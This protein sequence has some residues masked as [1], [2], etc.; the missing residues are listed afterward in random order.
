MVNFW[1]K[2]QKPI[3]ILAPMDD[4]T[5]TV[6]RQ[7]VIKVGRPDIFFTEFV[8][9]EGLFSPG[10]EIVKRRLKFDPSEKP[11]VA[12]IWGTKPENFFKAA[13]LLQSLGFDGIDINMGCPDRKVTK[14]GAGAALIENSQL[15]K[16]IILATQKGAPKLPI[17]VKTR[18]GFKTIKTEQWIGFLLKMNLAAL[19]IH[20]RTAAQ[21][22]KAAANWEEINRVV[23][24]RD[25]LGVNTLIIGNGDVE[26]WAQIQKYYQEYKVDGV[27]IGRGIFHN[28]GAFVKTAKE[29]DQSSQEKMK[30]L[31]DHTE[32]F[33]KTWGSVKNFAILRKFFKIYASGFKGASNLRTKLM[34]ANSLEEVELI[35]QN[36]NISLQ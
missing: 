23:K 1:T 8:N 34:R 12:Q 14:K 15:A 9:C 4:V 13:Q 20:G 10:A 30:L 28:L 2:I 3:S 25:E 7:I 19:T 26:D 24:L 33:I 36:D 11:L 29:G 31:I 17:S 32:L 35:L 21:M 6:F 18:I 5:D 16:E 27:M 22:S